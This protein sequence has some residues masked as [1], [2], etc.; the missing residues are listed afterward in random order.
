MTSDFRMLNL[1]MQR[2]KV[3]P[4][5]FVVPFCPQALMFSLS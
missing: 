5:L 4:G 2:Q 3:M 1:D